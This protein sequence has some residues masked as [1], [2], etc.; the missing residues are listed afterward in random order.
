MPAVL[1]LSDFTH[2]QTV[3][4]AEVSTSP[5]FQG[6]I[7]TFLSY[8]LFWQDVLEH[9]QSEEVKQTLLEHFRILFL[10]QLLYVSLPDGTDVPI[11]DTHLRYPS[12]LESS[13]IDGG[14][15][16]AVITYLRRILECISHS[17]LIRLILQY[18]FASSEQTGLEQAPLSRDRLSSRRRKSL[19]QLTHFAES[20]DKPSPSL[21]NLGDLI[22]TSIRSRSQPTVAATLKLVS[23]LIQKHH[24][25]TLSSLLRTSPAVPTPTQRTIGAHK[26]EMELMFSLVDS[27]GED[28]NIDASY[29]N[30]LQDTRDLLE[31][32]PCSTQILAV[33]TTGNT[34]SSPSARSIAKGSSEDPHLHK[35]KSDD[36]LLIAIFAALETFLTNSA[37]TNLNL[38][39]VIIALASCGYVLVE[40]WL[41]VDP[42]NYLY[43]DD[44][45]GSDSEEDVYHDL[46]L[47]L[48]EEL[49]KSSEN[50]HHR[51]LALRKAQR[52]PF[53]SAEDNSPVIAILQSLIHQVNL[54]RKEISGFDT[55]LRERKEIFQVE[56]KLTEAL[57]SMPPPMRSSQDSASFSTSST[58]S[59]DSAPRGSIS[60]RRF[61]EKVSALVSGSSSPRG[62]QQSNPLTTPPISRLGQL[63]LKG[64]NIPS[65]PIARAFSPSPLRQDLLS[66]PPS[67][68]QGLKPSDIDVLKRKIDMASK[69]P[70]AKILAEEQG[71]S[72][73]SSLFSN[74][75]TPNDNDMAPVEVSVS[76]LLTNVVILQEFILELAAVI[77]VRASLFEE[78]SF[79]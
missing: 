54:Y 73:T 7:N 8:L 51:I 34:A 33:H 69:G 67:R 5:E 6:H 79:V 20:E 23:V 45:S 41:V 18:L 59:P 38:T 12:L 64:S 76:H 68:T 2:P 71:G 17:E 32:H 16:V 21:F 11:A 46:D 1:V 60:Q 37:E 57:A 28:D 31:C 42:S 39:E 48:S 25:H 55:Y 49:D 24:H 78:V 56:E 61:P 35:L 77:Q 36:P 40:G 30:Y 72:D 63:T 65:Q 15:S 70:V 10:Q 52:S 66:S 74:S 43:D 26:K 19:D 62:R 22:L 4:E 27:F 50:E 14:S 3:P 44:N 75:T 13:D 47:A 9:C 53:W 58:I 29:E